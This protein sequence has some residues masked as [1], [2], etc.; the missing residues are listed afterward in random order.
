MNA[1]AAESEIGE[2]K[3]AVWATAEANKALAA[4]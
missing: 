2:K 1:R 3:I 4:A